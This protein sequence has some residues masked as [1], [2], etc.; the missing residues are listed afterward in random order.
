MVH[1]LDAVVAQRCSAGSAFTIPQKL[2][3]EVTLPGCQLVKTKLLCS[4]VHLY[5]TFDQRTLSTASPSRAAFANLGKRPGSRKPRGAH[6]HRLKRLFRPYGG[7][8]RCQRRDAQEETR[9]S[10]EPRRL[11]K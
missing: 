7:K 8:N 11:L 2:E 9:G 6:R 10:H 3:K 4:C 5:C 1:T